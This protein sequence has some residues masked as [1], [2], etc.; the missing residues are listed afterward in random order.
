MDLSKLTKDE[1]LTMKRN[2]EYDISKYFNFQLVK[3]IQLNS[4]YGAIGN[5]YFRYYSTDM[6]EAITLSG[7]LSIQF[8]GNEL[9]TFLNKNIGTDGID[10]II[11]SD[12]DSV[13]LNL[14][15]LVKKYL[16]TETD[17]DKICSYLDKCSKNIILPLIETKFNELATTMNAYENK[18]IMTRESIANKGIWT[19]KKRYIL[20][21]YDSEGVKYSTPELK[22]MG[23]ETTRSST[24]E[25]VRNDLKKCISIMI[26][27]DEEYLINF[28][29]EIKKSFNSTI[30]EDVSFP[31]RVNGLK[32]YTDTYYIYKK[33][34]PI[35]VKGAL[36]YNH[37]IKKMK[38]EKK[39]KLI[40]EGEKIK[41]VYLKTPNPF[42]G[43]TGE[44]HIISFP[45]R[46]PK[47]FELEGYI[48]YAKQ[49]EKSFL[50]PLATILNTIGWSYEK[51]N[52]LESL[53][54]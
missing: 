44:D 11:A 54:N 53:F 41:F 8:I 7:Q 5:Q 51:K 38:L 27:N 20:N 28:I 10:Y 47:E 48:D 9:N 21:V 31:R 49:F 37:H 16:P 15:S 23:I 29:K 4:A 12:T 40:Q 45:N 19:A 43:M 26:N 32:K 13:Y 52:T 2:L 36:I 14:G 46:I 33:F 34:T 17:N 25:I 24:P 35:A 30:P 1:L 39:Y 22:I 42:G 6:A 18:M 50:D 3:K